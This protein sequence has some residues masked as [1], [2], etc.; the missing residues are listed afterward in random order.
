[1][2]PEVE[3]ST[4]A[5]DK[6]LPSMDPSWSSVDRIKALLKELGASG[7]TFLVPRD[8]QCQWAS[9]VGYQCVYESYFRKDTRFWFPIPRLITSFSL[10][11][12]V[13]LSQF[14]NGSWRLAVGLMVMAAEGGWENRL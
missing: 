8:Y 9:L 10:R 13:P 3:R 14:V 12:D 1:M 11:R 5:G 7:V 6:S 2:A 4:S